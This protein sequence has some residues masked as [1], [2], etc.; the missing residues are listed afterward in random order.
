MKPPGEMPGGYC[1]R[2]DP[3]WSKAELAA[4]QTLLKNKMVRTDR[5]L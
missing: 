3:K 2:I 1:R 5:Y 4:K